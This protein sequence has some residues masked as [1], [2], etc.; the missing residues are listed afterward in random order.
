[1]SADPSHPNGE[2]LR[3]YVRN[4]LEPSDRALVRNHLRCCGQ[5]Q[6][7]VRRLD[8]MNDTILEAQDQSGEATATA[9]ATKPLLDLNATE[10][11]IDLLPPD[12]ADHPRFNVLGLLGTGG[13]GAVYRA[14]D[15]LTGWFVA[16][17]VLQHFD[18]ESF[19]RFKREISL[20]NSLKHPNLVLIQEASLA[21]TTPFIVMECVEGI[22]LDR[23]LLRRGLLQ[24]N[25]A[26]EI[27]RQA[28]QALRHA[29]DQGVVH[30]DVKPPNIMITPEGQVKLLDWG[31][32]RVLEGSAN[33][34]GLRLTQTN[35][36]V[37]TLEYIAPEQWNDSSTV[38]ARA[39]LF[40]LGGTLYTL[41][42]GLPPVT[43]NAA[44]PFSVSGWTDELSETLSAVRRDVK[45]S[46]RRLLARM[47]HP[48]RDRRVGSTAEAL[49]RLELSC[50]GAN[51][52]GLV[53]ENEPYAPVRAG[54]RRAR[55]VVLSGLALLLTAGALLAWWAFG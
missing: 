7:I 19:H 38:D 17:K 53:D 47:L 6:D 34:Q 35:Q 41:L 27:V 37:G 33:D 20:L 14:L 10:P 18:A 16:I 31:L 11:V 30:R 13:M 39:D 4:Q 54:S 23:L 8:A 52:V 5:C 3:A 29:H 51:L 26:C 45:P 44:Q 22:S 21:G 49:E 25:D 40:S 42:T 55:V 43:R 9:I 28:A 50:V 15:R 12:L 24:V 48:D 1:M 46:L 32:A 2:R 36:A